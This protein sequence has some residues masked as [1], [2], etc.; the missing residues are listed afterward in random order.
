MIGAIAQMV[1][2]KSGIMEVPIH[3]ES[4]LLQVTNLKSCATEWQEI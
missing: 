3:T 4:Q 2:V 1:V